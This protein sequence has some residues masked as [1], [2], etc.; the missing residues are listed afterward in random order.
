MGAKVWRKGEV[1]K[2]RVHSKIHTVDG[3][4]NALAQSEAILAEESRVFAQRVSLEVL[5]GRLAGLDERDVQVE[6]VGLGDSLDGRGTR[7]VLQDEKSQQS[8]T[9]KGYVYERLT[10]VV[11]RVPKAILTDVEMLDRRVEL[12]RREEKRNGAIEE[13][14][15]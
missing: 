12:G 8:D 10:A 1:E 14:F 13:F 9:N 11:K 4:S 3:N 6:A 15:F 2:L 7:L 5:S